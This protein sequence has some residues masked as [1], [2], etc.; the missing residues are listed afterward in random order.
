MAKN[1]QSLGISP[2]IA[3][4]LYKQ[5]I[6]E[7]T[8]VQAQAIPALFKGR[9]ILA[10]A[11][12]GTGKTYAFLLPSLQQIKTDVHMEQVLIVAPTR[13]LA[14][15]IA[16]VA[17]T[18]A[19]ALQVDVLSL[20][21]G[22]TIENQLQ[23]L[24]RHP[25]VIIGTPGRLLDHCR[26]NSLDLRGVKRV[27]VDEADQMRRYRYV[28]RHDAETTPNPLFLCYRTGQNQR[29]SQKAHAESVGL[30]HFGRH[31]DCAGTN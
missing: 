6:H 24:Q 16:D 20:I 10:Q 5:G 22:K 23:K 14:K 9:D 18:L 30:K 31:H 3:D 29:I 17:G 19:P 15:Q 4:M 8:A 26:R 1:F 12:T 28:N 2:Q 25:Q 11:Q 21:G 27:V 7:P 13:E